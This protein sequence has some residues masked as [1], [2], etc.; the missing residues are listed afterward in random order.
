MQSEPG[1][2]GILRQLRIAELNATLR[3]YA[4]AKLADAMDRAEQSAA[5]RTAAAERASAT[6][7]TVGEQLA[8]EDLTSGVK[9][10]PRKRRGEN[11][12]S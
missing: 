12:A 7:D 5:A 6:P 2:T 11:D 8:S 3:D 4:T 9:L 10:K 1:L